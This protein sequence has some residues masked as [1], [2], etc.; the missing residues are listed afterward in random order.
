MTKEKIITITL[1]IAV[2]L[3]SGFLGVS[4]ALKEKDSEKEITNKVT[5]VNKENTNDITETSTETTAD[6]A[7]SETPTTVNQNPNNTNSNNS[8]NNNSGNTSS[9]EET[10]QTEKSNH[11][12]TTTP[13]SEWAKPV[14]TTPSPSITYSEKDNEVI[15]TFNTIEKE[16]DTLLKSG[17][18]E[19]IKSKAKGVFITIVDF[20]FYDGQIN[21]VTFSELTEAGKQK[22]LSI[23]SSID[24]RIESKFPGY[25]ESISKT[26]SNA[27]N[28]ASEIIKS[29][30]NNIN[31]FAKEKLG[32]KNYQD[33]ID[34]KDE[35]V[36]YT[37]QA[38][39]IVGNVGSN[40]FNKGKDFLN[41]WYQ[42][43]KNSN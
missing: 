31:N 3:L 6:K 12:Q 32:D 23:A 43:F 14:T 24:N 35:L 18:N 7:T 36:L 29:G 20:I 37:K 21:G 4:F 27:F 40:L 8:S 10:N 16:V 13:I 28:K 34:A 41:N 19:S 33:I 15:A 22:V 1:V 25:K 11:N 2:I 38:L 5:E 17:T 30:A 9:K 26:A 39:S 42:N